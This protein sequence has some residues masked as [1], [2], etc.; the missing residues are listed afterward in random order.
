VAEPKEEADSTIDNE[1]KACLDQINKFDGYLFD[2]RK[3]GFTLITGLITAGSF[4]GFAPGTDFIHVGVVIVTMVLVAVL[5]WIDRYYQNILNK[6]LALGRFIEVDVGSGLL[7]SMSNLKASSGPSSKVL[8]VSAFYVG[9]ELAL[10]ILIIFTG[11]TQEP[12][13]GADTSQ[14]MM[15]PGNAVVP[16]AYENFNYRQIQNIQQVPINIVRDAIAPIIYGAA[17][18]IS[19]SLAIFISATHRHLE[20]QRKARD[21][22]IDG[23]LRSYEDSITPLRK[24]LAQKEREIK[25]ARYVQSLIEPINKSVR[26]RQN[27]IRYLIREI[28]NKENS[29]KLFETLTKHL[30]QMIHEDRQLQQGIL[31][32]EKEVLDKIEKQSNELQKLRGNILTERQTYKKKLLE[33]LER[34]K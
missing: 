27:T 8:P 23:V 14:A 3:Y 15:H 11:F 5:F 21:S 17:L 28:Q 7:A 10:F 24:D 20:K 1:W 26:D 16:T 34:D 6:V 32:R 29:F 31:A 25:E 2:L 18:I 9:F 4:L 30:D 33:I 12:Q 19:T 13:T 22:K